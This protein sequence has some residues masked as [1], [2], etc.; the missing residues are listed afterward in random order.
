VIG[1]RPL[2]DIANEIKRD[3][4]VINNRSAKQALD[5]MKTMGS[6]EDPF[7]LIPTATASS[8][9][10]SNIRGVGG[11]RSQDALNPSCV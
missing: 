7:I 10:S 5:H 4:S 9:H 3:W 6:I 11:G 1:S 8:E 2:R